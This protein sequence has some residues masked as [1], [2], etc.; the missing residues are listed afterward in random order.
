[1]NQ[2]EPIIEVVPPTS[3]PDQNP[4]VQLPTVE[5][6]APQA[7]APIEAVYGQTNSVEDKVETPPVEADSEQ[8]MRDGAALTK[9]V[10]LIQ[11]LFLTRQIRREPRLLGGDS[12]PKSITEIIGP[13][14]LEE[15]QAIAAKANNQQ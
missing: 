2:E 14:S 7:G 9:I 10:G 5:G 13:K 4:G 15:R 12:I 3:N 11:P 6:E 8:T 1:M